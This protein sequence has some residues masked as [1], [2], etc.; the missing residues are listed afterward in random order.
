MGKPR[1]LDLWNR[2][3]NGVDFVMSFP[4]WPRWARRLFIVT[5]PVSFALYCMFGFV[6]LFV[7]IV[8][9]AD[10]IWSEEEL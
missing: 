5:F 3:Q 7:T 8:V 2:C 4:S 6:Y 9:H 10:Q 1:K